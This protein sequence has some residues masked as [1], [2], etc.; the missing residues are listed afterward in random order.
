MSDLNTV[1]SESNNEKTGSSVMGEPVY[2][3]VGRLGKPHGVHG[4]AI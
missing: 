4:E 3:A 2:I 1:S